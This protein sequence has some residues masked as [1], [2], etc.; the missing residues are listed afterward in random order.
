MNFE[1]V[2]TGFFTRLG[3]SCYMVLATSYQDYP[4][5]SMMTC[6]VFDGCIWM[7]TDKKFSK[8]QQIL[9]NN[10]VALVKNAVQIEGRAEIT[11]HPLEKQNEKFARLMKK[12]HPESYDMYSKV[13][14]EVVIKVTP[15]KAIDWLYE[16][17]SNE[18]HNIDFVNQKV[19]VT[20][21]KEQL[22][23]VKDICNNFEEVK[24]IDDEETF[25]FKIEGL[26][27]ANCALELEEEIQIYKNGK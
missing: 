25:S 11:G 20:C 5:R 1:E 27:C 7:Q 22:L 4:M 12:Y 15:E 13:D 26:D 8:Y 18:I 19:K 3:E 6:L 16:A 10:R 23:K 2:K 17:G 21:S 9:N 24:V 14:S